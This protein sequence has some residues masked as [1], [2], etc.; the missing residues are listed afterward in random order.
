[1]IRSWF[2]IGVRGTLSVQCFTRK[3]GQLP[4]SCSFLS[5]K[6]E[7]TTAGFLWKINFQAELKCTECKM[8]QRHPVFYLMITHTQWSVWRASVFL[9][10]LQV[11]C[12]HGNPA[13]C[14]AVPVQ[15]W[16]CAVGYS[17]KG[18]KRSI[19]CVA[20]PNFI[21]FIDQAQLNNHA[22]LWFHRFWEE[23][24]KTSNNSPTQKIQSNS[25]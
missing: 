18:G 2:K 1:M 23:Y 19:I 12:D 3:K 22:Q 20:S 14:C 16:I 25:S 17:A 6:P 8:C 11:V 13:V 5:N 10:F 9:P 7:Q 15:V 4:H 21:P 24:Y